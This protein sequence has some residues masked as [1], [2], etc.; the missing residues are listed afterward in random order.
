[1]TTEQDTRAEIIETLAHYGD[2]PFDDQMAAFGTDV[3]NVPRYVEER[4]EQI[5]QYAGRS[6]LNIWC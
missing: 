1:M 3:W 5:V 2:V 4:R 6:D